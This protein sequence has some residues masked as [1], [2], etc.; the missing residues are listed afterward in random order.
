MKKVYIQA[1]DW[2]DARTKLRNMLGIRN[3][4]QLDWLGDREVEQ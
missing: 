1:E 4:S 3:V 2:V